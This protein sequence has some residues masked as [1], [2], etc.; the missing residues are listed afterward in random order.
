MKRFV[1]ISFTLGSL[2]AAFGPFYYLEHLLTIFIIYSGI[3]M[4]LTLQIFVGNINSIVQHTFVPSLFVGVMAG[5]IIAGWDTWRNRRDQ[6]STVR[7]LPNLFWC[8]GYAFLLFVANSSLA[9]LSFRYGPSGPLKFFD[10]VFPLFGI[11]IP[12]AMAIAW[13]AIRSV[14]TKDVLT[15]RVL[16]D[17]LRE[18]A[19]VG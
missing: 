16:R 2:G 5:A 6:S 1:V 13:A 4:G 15:P 9:F 11:I 10:Q 3:T 12:N 19:R 17:K 8:G 14:T 7:L 18:R